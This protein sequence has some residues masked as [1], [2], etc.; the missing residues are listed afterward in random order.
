MLFNIQDCEI[1]MGLFRKNKVS[2]DESR[3]TVEDYFKI[4]SKENPLDFLSKHICPYL[5]GSQWDII[6]KCALLMAVTNDRA[7]VRMRLHLLLYGEPGS[8]KTE[9]LSWWQQ[10]MNG[11]LIN[12]ELTSKIGLVGD[13]RGKTI[14]PGL[15]S[16]YSGHVLLVDELDKMKP[17]DQN[18][19]LQAMEEGSYTITKGKRSQQ[20]QA[21]VRIMASCNNLS[22]IQH[23]LLDRFDFPIQVQRIQR[24]Q[25]A[26]FVSDI[27]DSFMGKGGKEYSAV[28]RGYIQWARNNVTKVDVSHERLIKDSIKDYI[29]K[30]DSAIEG[31]SY[32]SLE[33]SILR[34]AYAIALLEKSMIKQ[35]HVLEA[36][37]MKDWLLQNFSEE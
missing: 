19:L 10:K 9:F 33:F 16:R 23:P 21:E 29:L 12:S 6:R 3:M 22:K 34:I 1:G 5:V 18:G 25:R 27:I 17:S 7:H 32:R 8:G 13:A 35:R 24:V 14:T 31:I 36:I 37:K 2:S 30:T 4:I 26:E 20:F 11:K 28:V 15:L